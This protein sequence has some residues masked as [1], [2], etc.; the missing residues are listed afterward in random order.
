MN[1]SLRQF[2]H[3]LSVMAMLSFSHSGLAE[4]LPEYRLKA[5]FLYNFLAFTEWP[6]NTGPTLTLC[7]YG[8]DPFGPDITALEGKEVN[9][10]RIS[11]ERRSATDSTVG[12]QATFVTK[13]AMANLQHMLAET[14]NLPN[15]TVADSPNA[16]SQGVVLNLAVVRNKITFEANQTAANDAGLKL[17]S[18]LLR[19]ATEVR[20]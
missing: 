15:L 13:S 16:I 4:E 17:S 18:K 19:L 11:V 9:S 20:Q 10:R 12:C 3:V 7:I 8:D 5:A 2:L 14:R 6:S 1:R